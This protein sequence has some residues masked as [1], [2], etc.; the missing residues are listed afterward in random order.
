MGGKGGE[1]VQQTQ[2]ESER[3]SG[4]FERDLEGKR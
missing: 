2:E 1:E 3:S 4:G